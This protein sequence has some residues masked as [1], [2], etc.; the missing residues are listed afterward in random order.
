VRVIYHHRTQGRDVE[1][2][3]IR[4]LS[5]GLEQLGFEVE[6]VGPPGVEAN[7][8]TV[9]SA[10]TGKAGTPWGAIARKMPQLGFELLELGY[11]LA[12][13]PR[14]L[15]R[16][17]RDKPAFIYERYALYNAAGVLAGRLARIPVV[18][19]VN[20]TAKVDRTRQGKKL[21]MP[22]LA[23][24]VERFIFRQATGMTVVS[25]YLRDQLVEMGV[26]P[27][28]VLVTPNAVDAECFD[29]ERRD[30]STVRAR[31]GLRDSVVVGF[32][33]SFAKWHGVDFLI[34]TCARLMPEFPDL[35]LLLIGDGDRRPVSEALAAELGVADRVIF[36]GRVPHSAIPEYVA[37]MDVGVMPASNV[38]GSPMKIF[39]Y[40]AMGRPAVG[41][42]YLPLEEAIDDGRTG[43]L[44]TPD[45]EEELTGCLRELLQDPERRRRMGRAAR[46]KVLGR[47]L[48]V[49][50]ARAVVEL[51]RGERRYET[52]I[53]QTA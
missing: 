52:A 49:H 34:R 24:R 25:G 6:V 27:E 47:H 23:A 33:G 41:P 13:L 19:E 43:L 11:N 1:A 28:R 50:N 20:D 40:M 42:R 4:G 14:L 37:A 38:F 35:R 15:A 21:V 17:R 46:E 9:A 51:A 31:L 8:N 48:W 53:A 32:A 5:G 26:P 36:T 30:G 22:A 10:A 16:C 44:F 45:S 39:E 29:P 12:A 2:V 7:P 3:H 18:L